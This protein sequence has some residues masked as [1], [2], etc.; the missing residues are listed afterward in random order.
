MFTSFARWMSRVMGTRTA[1]MLTVVMCVAWVSLAPLVDH[2]MSWKGMLIMN[3]PTLFTL[4]MVVVV[5][6]T[7]NHHDDAVQIKLDE[8]I[9]AVQGAHNSMVNLEEL[10]PEELARVKAKYQALAT[11]VR[12]SGGAGAMAT[13]TPFI[14]PLPGL[15][16]PEGG[17][18]DAP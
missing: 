13:N 3:V 12:D 15:P 6:H 5:Q 11:R 14:D 18:K 8:L 7:Q 9:R 2:G 4:L 1:L 17:G 10:S 16:G